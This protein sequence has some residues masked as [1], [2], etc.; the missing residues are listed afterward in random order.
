MFTADLTWDTGTTEK[1]GQRRERKVKAR[2]ESQNSN[3]DPRPSTSGSRKWK[4]SKKSIDSKKPPIDL[5][6]TPIPPPWAPTER[7]QTGESLPPLSPAPRYQSE[8]EARMF[9]LTRKQSK[10]VV[11]PPHPND[12]KDPEEQPD[13]TLYG[14][15]NSR[16]LPSGAPLHVEY[17]DVP[18]SPVRTGSSKP[19]YYRQLKSSMFVT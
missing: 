19:D 11:P 4:T 2:A 6:I 10:G 18:A 15:L 8:V 13:W 12:A 3:Y 1:V 17:V 16:R 5:S 7:P 9:N 14:T